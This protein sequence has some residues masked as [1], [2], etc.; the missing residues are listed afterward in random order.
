MT[1]S[2][3]AHDQSITPGR[4]TSPVPGTPATWVGAP[5]PRAPPRPAHGRAAAH[6]R[7]VA[8][9]ARGVAALE[10][11]GVVVDLDLRGD[12][13][14]ARDG[15]DVVPATTR[16]VPRRMDPAPASARAEGVPRRGRGLRRDR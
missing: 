15:E 12:D 8:A 4:S 7:L 5:S 6:R 2:L 9:H 10:T 14:V 13:E 11:L 16:V 1:S 3:A